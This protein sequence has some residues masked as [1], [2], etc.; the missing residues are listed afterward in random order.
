MT[1]MTDSG[2]QRIIVPRSSA[3]TQGHSGLTIY[4]FY[5]LSSY[6]FIH[7]DVQIIMSRARFEHDSSW[8]CHRMYAIALLV[9]LL[10]T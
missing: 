3:W 10:V 9:D 5:G 8:T 2:L 1:T 7:F 6:L 4:S